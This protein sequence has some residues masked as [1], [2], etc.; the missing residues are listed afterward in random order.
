MNGSY[1]TE[2][3]GSTL[4]LNSGGWSAIP[5]KAG[6]QKRIWKSL[7]IPHNENEEPSCIV[8][9]TPVPS[10]VP[11]SHGEEV[12]RLALRDD[13]S[14]TNGRVGF[15][16]SKVNTVWDASRAIPIVAAVW[17]LQKTTAGRWVE[18]PDWR[19]FTYGYHFGFELF[20]WIRM[21]HPFVLRVGTV[22]PRMPEFTSYT[23]LLSTLTILPRCSNLLKKGVLTTWVTISGY[24]PLL[25]L[26]EKMC[27]QDPSFKRPSQRFYAPRDAVSM[28]KSTTFVVIYKAGKL[29]L[30]VS[31][32]YITRFL[33]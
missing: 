9:L 20:C 31:N 26:S 12:R 3:N 22:I 1:Y 13:V 10:A 8:P 15:V 6:F 32:C 24:S 5:R 7:K 16:M 11:L 18:T 19:P 21:C 4:A 23:N 17:A 25:S 2:N 28:S 14:Y 27:P 29:P 30:E 33:Y